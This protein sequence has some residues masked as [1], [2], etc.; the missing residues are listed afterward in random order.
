MINF[1]TIQFPMDSICNKNAHFPRIFLLF[2]NYPERERKIQKTLFYSFFFSFLFDVSL[3]FSLSL[4]LSPLPQFFLSTTTT[5]TI[6]VLQNMTDT[7]ELEIIE[8]S[9]PF[10]HEQIKIRRGTIN[11]ASST[12]RMIS[13]CAGALVTSTLSTIQTFF[14]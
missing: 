10:H 9:A 1:I 14:Y 8:N 12:E 6:C 2:N 7:S 3:Y 5:T 13:A 11:H 4:S